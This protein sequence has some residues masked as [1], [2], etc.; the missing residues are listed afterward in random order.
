[1]T[2]MCLARLRVGPVIE[3]TTIGIRAFYKFRINNIYRSVAIAFTSPA[4]R[5]G[6]GRIAIFKDKEKAIQR[7]FIWA[8]Y[9]A[10][11]VW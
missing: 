1:M 10:L 7:F 11:F 8:F 4:W 2:T 5:R 3:A 6:P 9:F